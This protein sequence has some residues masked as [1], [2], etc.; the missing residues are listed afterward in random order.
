M[1]KS[2][3]PVRQA[4]AVLI[5]LAVVIA[6]IAILVSPT[7][8]ADRVELFEVGEEFGPQVLAVSS[9]SPLLAFRNGGIGTQHSLCVVSAENGK[10]TLRQVIPGG[11]SARFIDK[12]NELL[13]YCLRI[14]PHWRIYDRQGVA[15][16]AW[17]TNL[18]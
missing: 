8:V 1:S 10:L 3:L 13:V 6:A 16:R 5:A 4:R 14:K 18:K 7:P 12:S 9:N 11:T 15:N 17:D 2:P